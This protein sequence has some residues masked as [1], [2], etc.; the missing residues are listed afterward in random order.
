MKFEFE[1]DDDDDSF[2]TQFESVDVEKI[3]EISSLR[4]R[5]EKGVAITQDVL[6]EVTDVIEAVSKGLSPSPL[7]PLNMATTLH[8]IAKN[9]EKVYMF[10]SDRLGFSRQRDMA[11]L[12][13]LGMGSLPHLSAQGI[14]NIA[15]ALS[16]IG[17]ETIYWSEMDRIEEFSM[18]R[19][20]EFN[21]QNVSNLAGAFASMQHAAPGLFTALA[22]R[23][24]CM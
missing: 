21:T 24:Y 13:I 1:L 4:E 17:G 12:V 16:K 19:M 15:W 10:K 23:A 9:M 3:R 6:I 7:N 8:R 20:S 5:Y 11:M 14:S 2:D 22:K 18:T